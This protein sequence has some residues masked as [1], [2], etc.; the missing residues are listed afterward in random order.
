MFLKI[1]SDGKYTNDTNNIDA[2]SAC[3]YELPEVDSTSIDEIYEIWH[4]LIQST[5]KPKI[6]QFSIQNLLRK[7]LSPR[8]LLADFKLSYYLASQL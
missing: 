1:P 3:T 5:D 7:G 8:Y 4:Q 6:S 2:S